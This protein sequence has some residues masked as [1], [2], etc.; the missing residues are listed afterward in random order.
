M[1]INS[2][3]AAQLDETFMLTLERSTIPRGLDDGVTLSS[4]NR[5]RKPSFRTN[6]RLRQVLITSP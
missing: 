6:Q 2:T 5:K 1:R 3:V 4:R